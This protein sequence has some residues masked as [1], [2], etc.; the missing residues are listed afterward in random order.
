MNQ[1]NTGHELKMFGIH[2]VVA[3]IAFALVLA[4]GVGAALLV[5]WALPL[6]LASSSPQ[7]ALEASGRILELHEKFW[8]V[9]LVSL[10]G[11][12]LAAGWLSRRITGPLVR[13]VDAFRRIAEGGL[14]API[15]IRATDYLVHEVNE[16]NTMVVALKNRATERASLRGE[17]LAALE[18]LSEHASE[19][20]DDT[21]AALVQRALDKMKA[22]DGS[23][24]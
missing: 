1:R 15:H 18:E 6:E 12:A 9:V 3:S 4:L 14:P 2:L 23:P 10:S 16:L 17:I 7:K 20:E 24:S 21:L 22:L 11:V 5:R 19:S 13:F 8:P